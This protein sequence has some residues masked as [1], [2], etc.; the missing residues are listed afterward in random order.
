MVDNDSRVL[1]WDNQSQSW[2]GQAI[3]RKYDNG[4]NDSGVLLI[5]D[6]LRGGFAKAIERK[7]DNG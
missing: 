6:N 1:I 4:D 3:D 2:F 7:C 5:W